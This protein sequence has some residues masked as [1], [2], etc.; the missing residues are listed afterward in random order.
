MR[1]GTLARNEFLK[2]RRW[3]A[4]QVAL[5]VFIALMAMFFGAMYNSGNG[6]PNDPLILP[7]AWNQILGGPGILT[8]FFTSFTVILLVSSEFTWRTAR[9]NVIDGLSME[10]FFTAK[11][12]MVPVVCALFLGVL[13]ALGGSFG[14]AANQ[15]ADVAGMVVR[16]QDLAHMAGA[17]LGLLGWAS[18]AFFFAMTTRSS[19]PAV[20]AFFLY[21]LIEQVVRVVVG[22]NGPAAARLTGI[23]PTAVFIELWNAN[24]YDARPLPTAFILGSP[25]ISLTVVLAFGVGYVALFVTLAFVLY[26]GRDL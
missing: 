6:Q 17:F 5:F 24:L 18:L 23:F 12:L 10:E 8:V 16:G 2:A 4:V 9:Q 19:G 21:F 11:L 1:I 3:P 14:V 26:R 22:L 7:D 13:L 15:L 20:G 25:P